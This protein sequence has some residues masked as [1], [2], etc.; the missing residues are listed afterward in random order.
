MDLDH[1]LETVKVNFSPLKQKKKSIS[2]IFRIANF[3]S[4][5]TLGRLHASSLALKFHDEE[6]FFQ[7][8]APLKEAIFPQGTSPHLGLSINGS[9]EAAIAHLEWLEPKNE[10]LEAGIRYLKTQREKAHSQ[11]QDLVLP[12]R[13]KHDVLTHGDCWNNNVMFRHDAEGKVTDVK[14]LDFQIVRHASP[15]LDF[16]YF[17]YSSP[18]SEVIEEHYEELVTG[19][20]KAFANT[21]RAKSSAS[22]EELEFLTDDVWFRNELK[23]NAKYG[24]FTACWIASAILAEDNDAIDMDKITKEDIEALAN[25]TEIKIKPKIAQRIRTIVLDYMQRYV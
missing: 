23:A 10:E 13:K 14:L 21:L 3:E 24:L 9:L 15:A 12:R 17:V 22:K 2:L 18:K 7:F 6:K 4:F 5:Q 11:I 16:H 20:H 25:T 1:S 19:Y 8:I